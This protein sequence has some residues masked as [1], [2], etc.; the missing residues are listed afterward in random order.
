MFRSASWKLGHTITLKE[1]EVGYVDE[2]LTINNTNPN[3]GM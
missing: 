1:L 2:Y 3:K